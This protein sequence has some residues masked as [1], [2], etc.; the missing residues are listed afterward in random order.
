MA[1]IIKWIFITFFILGMLM[2]ILVSNSLDEYSAVPQ[3][4]PL[5]SDELRRVKQFIKLNNLAELHSAYVANSQIDQ[6]DI[7]QAL[8]YIAQKSPLL[9]GQRLNAK[10]I[11]EQQQALV[12]LSM[13]LPSN[14]VG[15]YLNARIKLR[16][17]NTAAQ[18]GIQIQ[19][20]QI[21]KNQLPDF[22]VKLVEEK[23]HEQL[24]SKVP[25]YR[26]V[27]QSVKAIH[28][29]KKQLSVEYIWHKQA[30]DK[31]KSQLSSR[32]I[33][34]EFKQALLAHAN[35]L[36]KLSHRLPATARLNDLIKPMFSYAQLRS[37]KH[38]PVI[39]NRALFVALGAYSLNKNI[40][41]LL[42]ETAEEVAHSQR[43]YIK[44]RH[45]LSKHFMLSAAITSLANPALANSIGLQKEVKDSQGG[46]GF[47]FA[48]LAADHAGI[49]LAE[50]STASKEQAI[51]IQN[52]LSKAMS[53]SAY[54]PNI[55]HLPEGLKKAEFE[56][57]YTNARRYAYRDLEQRI[58]YRIEKLP[59]YQ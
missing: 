37:E 38:N 35:Y 18:A 31:I 17:V 45:D 43:I 49:A 40:P 11:F 58:A 12:Q 4:S 51:K 3:R 47:S 16:S 29:N 23:L 13:Q 1:R 20:I 46:S 50:K 32:V 19:S 27:L 59:V 7:N 26:M 36:A 56:R 42:G 2:G 28:F 34:D 10:V 30:V 41:E 33:S 15:Q 54:M 52:A 24:K 5:S 25:E 21:G 22:I 14:P 55:D 57:Q 9:L 53:E 39:E 6:Q 44:E 48:D 8:R